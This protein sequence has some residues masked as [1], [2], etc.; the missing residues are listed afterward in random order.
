MELIDNKT[1]GYYRADSN[2]G[3]VKIVIKYGIMKVYNTENKWFFDINDKS[4]FGEMDD[5]ILLVTDKDKFSG[6]QIY[7]PL[8]EIKYDTNERQDF[9]GWTRKR[10]FEV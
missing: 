3:Q 6:I 7:K 5:Y 9:S 8:E 2:I 4:I 1:D 10:K